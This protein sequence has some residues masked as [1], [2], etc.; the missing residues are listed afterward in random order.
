MSFG[1][2]SKTKVK[3]KGNK[4]NN[5]SQPMVKPSNVEPKSRRV[6]EKPYK[7]I[8]A[9]YL[10]DDFYLNLLDWSENDQIV[11]ALDSSA[12]VWSSCST[13]KHKIYQTNHIND[14]LCSVSFCD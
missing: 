11:V 2:G 12:Y 13:D 14:Y 7:T 10:Q 4:E 1:K 6:K 9:P 5:I 8:E 3:S